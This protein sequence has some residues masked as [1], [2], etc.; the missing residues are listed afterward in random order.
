MEVQLEDASER[1]ASLSLQGPLSRTILEKAIGRDL[2]ALKYF[3]LTN[4]TIG[5]VTVVVSRTGYTGDLGER[6]AMGI[7]AA[8]SAWVRGEELPH[9]VV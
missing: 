5:G 6:V 7:H 9:R 8:L 4:A 2:A 3:R 1:V